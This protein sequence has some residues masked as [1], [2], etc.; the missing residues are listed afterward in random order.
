MIIRLRRLLERDRED[1]TCPDCGERLA[2]YGLC[3]SGE[4]AIIEELELEGAEWWPEPEY[5]EPAPAW[6]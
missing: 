5:E 1:P 4:A 3:A 2:G 6:G